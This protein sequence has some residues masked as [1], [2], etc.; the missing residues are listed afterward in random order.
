MMTRVPVG[1]QLYSVREDCARDLPGTLAEI[2]KMGY[3]GVE[4]AGFHGYTAPE[5]RRMLDD[6]DL[7]CCG[8]HIDVNTLLGDDLTD[9]IEFH[10][11]IG[12]PYLIVPG[13]AEEM[14]D[15]SEAW[16]GTARLFNRIA[17]QVKPHAMQVGY[18]NHTVEFLDYS[19]Q[20]GFDIFFGN[21]VAEVIMQLDIGNALEAG[22]D[23]MAIINRYPGR[24]VTIHFKEYSSTNPNALLGQGDVQ[25]QDV[26]RLCET[27]GKT[28]WYIVEQESYPFP[29]MECIA[30]CRK[31]L[32][33]LGR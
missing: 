6:L 15:S 2:R 10:R 11:M 31:A 4:F 1:V 14:R 21:T 24:A 27:S 32:T 28:A 7:R 20:T 30:A 8:A 13:L 25:W 18:H 17:A 19:G 5:V 29:P 22:S 16:K 23:P 26:I 9:T 33:D 12:N 3:D